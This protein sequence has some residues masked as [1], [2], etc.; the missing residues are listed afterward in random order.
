MI[1][2]PPRSTLF[3]Y[4]TL[5]RSVIAA[6]RRGVDTVECSEA[7]RRSLRQADRYRSVQF[8]HRRWRDVGKLPVKVDDPQPARNLPRGRVRVTGG[9]GGPGLVRLEGLHGARAIGRAETMG[10][11]RIF[12]VGPSLIVK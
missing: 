12:L 10:G 7:G 2:R 8:D 6:Q 5:F 11:A 9:E 3:P 4:T 1:R